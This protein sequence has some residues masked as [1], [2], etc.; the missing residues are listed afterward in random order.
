MPRTVSLDQ[1]VQIA[2]S[3]CI[4]APFVLVQMGRLTASS[5]TYLLLNLVDSDGPVSLP[6]DRVATVLVD[7]YD[8][9]VTP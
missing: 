2:A 6:D 3:L 7:R 9:A 8:N 5:R 1:A 4:L